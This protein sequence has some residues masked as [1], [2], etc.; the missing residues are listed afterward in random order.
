MVYGK[1]TEKAKP[2]VRV[3][4]KATDLGVK[5]QKLPRFGIMDFLESRVAEEV[6]RLFNSIYIWSQGRTMDLK[7]LFS[8]RVRIFLWDHSE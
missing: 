8:T 2:S 7:H 6:I 5:V 3:R 1:N 4:R